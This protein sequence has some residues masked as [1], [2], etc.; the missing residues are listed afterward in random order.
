MY[1]ILKNPCSIYTLGWCLYYLQGTLYTYGSMWGKVIL[2][3]LILYSGLFF[4]INSRLYNTKYFRILFCIFILFIIYTIFGYLSGETFIY[5]GTAVGKFEMLKNVSISIMPIVCY[6]GYARKGYL[7]ESWFKYG[8]VVLLL[9]AITSFYWEQ[10]YRLMMAME[11]GSGQ[12]EFTNNTGYLFA[13]IIPLLVLIDSKSWY[14]YTLLA[15]SFLFVLFS[16]KRGAILV[17][18]IAAAIF[19]WSNIKRSKG[20]NKFFIL[21]LGVVVMAVLSQAVSYL[22]E[23]SDYFNFRIQQTAEGASSGRDEMYS[24]MINY[25]LN[26]TSVFKFLFGNGI[27]GTGMIF[28][29]GAHNDWIEFAIDMGIFGLIFYFIY[30]VRFYKTWHSSKGLGT[31][32]TALGIIFISELLKSLFSFSINDMPIQAAPALGYCLAAI[33]M[34]RYKSA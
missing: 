6:Y 21:L 3:L 9:L 23:N 24:Q 15:I 19:L 1:R 16:M 25:F 32:Y 20:F 22:I 12:E 7:S 26:E 34:H 18:V 4:I 11:I 5:N 17:S 8:A 29:N 33:E 13:A 27:N 10:S 31:V 30:W 14:K 2:F 28:G